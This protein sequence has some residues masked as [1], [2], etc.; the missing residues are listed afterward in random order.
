MLAPDS[1]V[2]IWLAMSPSVAAAFEFSVMVMP[3]PLT[4]RLSWL[5]AL[6]MFTVPAFAVELTVAAVASP[7]P[8]STVTRL[9]AEAAP[10]MENSRFAV[11]AAEPDGEL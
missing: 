5:L 3:E 10:L 7:C 6:L 4:F 9:L 8:R 11:P 1:A 2:E